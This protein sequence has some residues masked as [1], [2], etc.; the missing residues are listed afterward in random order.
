MV[1]REGLI[2]RVQ[3]NRP[4]DPVLGALH[5]RF[6]RQI[7][8]LWN[9]TLRGNRDLDWCTELSFDGV[10][11]DPRSLERWLRMSAAR[12]ESYPTQRSSLLRDLVLPSFAAPSTPPR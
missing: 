5:C 7:R 2:Q 9:W 6:H 3:Q 11:H 4:N 12:A 8:L 1:D 10:V